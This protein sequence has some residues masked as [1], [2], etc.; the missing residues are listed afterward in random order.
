MGAS[1]AQ[2]GSSGSDW[3]DDGA[4]LEEEHRWF[5]RLAEEQRRAAEDQTASDADR[6][7]SDTDQ[8]LA[9]LERELSERD[10]QASDRDRQAAERDQAASDRELELHSD[11]ASRRAHEA[12][13]AGREA[14][15]LERD[16]ASKAR[17]L[18]AEE[19][20]RHAAGRDEN[21]RQRDLT[22]DARDRAAEQRDREAVALERKIGFRGSSLRAALTLAAQTRARAA[23][24]RARA[25]EERGHAARDRER[26]ATERAEVLAELR[27]AHMD[28]LTGA[29]RRGAGEVALQGEIDRVRLGDGRL[30]LAF[31]DVD[32][33]R[34]LNKRKGHA[35]GDALLRDVVSAIQTTGRS[36]EPIVRYGGDE[37][38]CALSGVDMAQA[39]R[40]FAAIRESVAA[41]GAGEV[42]SVGLAELRPEDSLSDLVGRA[43]TALLTARQVHPGGD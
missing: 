41:D 23:A 35:A 25:A 28:A 19:R 31:V 39:E 1:V 4:R 40:R 30:V 36:Y 3:D 22:A 7:A 17:A 11:E 26:A 32:S 27:R 33:L 43:D 8:S 6:T 18:T 21:A 10:Q 2:K 9:D 13:R 42:L 37:F 29:L 34:D 15:R 14:G 38:V 12:G 16:Q 24:D 5:A 20:A